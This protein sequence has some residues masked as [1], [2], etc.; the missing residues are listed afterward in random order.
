M[1]HLAP[2]VVCSR[3]Q[4]LIS[5]CRRF[6]GFVSEW[7]R[8][9]RTLD[10][11]PLFEFQHFAG[12]LNCTANLVF[13]FGH[14]TEMVLIFNALS[15]SVNFVARRPWFSRGVLHRLDLHDRCEEP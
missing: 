9:R 1:V 5:G 10:A 6:V 15:F 7:L 3:E 12:V 13:E 2:H 4:S 14:V 11:S 8:R